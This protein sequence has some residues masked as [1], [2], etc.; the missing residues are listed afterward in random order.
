MAT[1]NKIVADGTAVRRVFYCSCCGKLFRD[2]PK[3]F[4]RCGSTLYRS[5]SQYL[6][7]CTQCVDELY[8]TYYD[9]YNDAAKACRRVCAKLDVYYNDRVFQ[10]ALTNKTKTVMGYYMSKIQ[11]NQMFGKTFDDTIYEMMVEGK[12]EMEAFGDVEAGVAQDSVPDEVRQFW[13]DGFTKKQYEE[14]Q[15]CYDRWTE[16]K[17]MAGSDEVGLYRQI[18]IA[19]WNV[20]NA[21]RKGVKSEQ[22]QQVLNSLLSKTSVSEKRSTADDARSLGEK[23]RDWEREAPIPEPAPEFQDVDNI[24]R[25]IS[26]WFLGH[27][28]KM[29]GIKNS[30]NRMYEEEMKKYTVD[31]P[32]YIESDDDESV[33]DAIF[34]NKKGGDGA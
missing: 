32:E 23:I 3:N 15:S 10:G 6:N 5:N 11:S 7:V 4:Y 22:Q 14:L 8:D 17:T 19:D 27:F 13:G 20:M 1:T 26:T 30:Y 29:F 2:Q 12:T 24:V 33:F 34:G 28:C 21:T 9:K 25:Y 18:A 16:G 31:R